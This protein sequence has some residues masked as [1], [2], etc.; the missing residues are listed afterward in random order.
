MIIIYWKVDIHELE[1]R[2]N[3]HI[4]DLLRNHEKSF[5]ELKTYYNDITRQNLNLIKGQKHEIGKIHA[6]CQSNSKTLAQKK[7]TNRNLEA[8][9]QEAIAKRDFLKE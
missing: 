1:E 5:K 3:L 7:E 8:P 6:S 9:L 2:K 4:N